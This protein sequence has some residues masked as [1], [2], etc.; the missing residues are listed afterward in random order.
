MATFI[1]VQSL[2]LIPNLDLVYVT[3]NNIVVQSRE[4]NDTMT[5]LHAFIAGDRGDKHGGLTG[6][7]EDLLQ[8]L[9][10]YESAVEESQDRLEGCIFGSRTGGKNTDVLRKSHQHVRVPS[11]NVCSVQ[12]TLANS[13]TC[14]NLVIKPLFSH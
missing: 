7:T 10:I 3:L 9:G 12:Q 6:K 8:G 5:E 13:L 14:V 1:V 4:Q 2:V 11:L